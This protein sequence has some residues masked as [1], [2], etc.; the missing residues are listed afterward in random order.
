[1]R[2]HVKAIFETTVSS[3]LQDAEQISLL[4]GSGIGQIYDDLQHFDIAVLMR[5]VR[6]DPTMT[7]DAGD[8]RNLSVTFSTTKRSSANY[9]TPD[10][11][12]GQTISP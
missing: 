12:V 8:G 5:V 11:L 10:G 4:Q 7:D 6:I 3:R 9:R 2:Q 1:L